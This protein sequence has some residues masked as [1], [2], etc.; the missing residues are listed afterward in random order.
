MM[1]CQT[2]SEGG[3]EGGMRIIK[4]GA[5]DGESRRPANVEESSALSPTFFHHPSL[6]NGACSVMNP[7]DL[8]IRSTSAFALKRTNRSNHS[9]FR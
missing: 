4:R 3:R 6:L 9:R 1:K 5:T 8:V 2:G 7:C